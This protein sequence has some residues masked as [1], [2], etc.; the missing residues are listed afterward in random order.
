MI[1]LAEDELEAAVQVFHVR[2][3][4]VRGQRGWVVDKVEDVATGDLVEHLLQQVY[5][6]E[7]GDAVPREVLVPA[8]PD[9]AASR[10][11]LAVRAARRRG[12]PAGAAARR[13]ARPARDRGAQRAAGPDPAQDPARPA[14]SRPG[15][16]PS[17]ELQ[18]ALGLAEA[19]L[20]IEC[21][22]VSNL[23][24]T[25]VV[26]SMVVFEDGLPRKSRVPPV[27][28]PRASTGRTTSR[29][30]ARWSAAAS[31]A[32]STSVETGRPTS[33][34]TRPATDAR[35]GDVRAR[36]RPRDRPAAKFAYPPHLVV[37]DG[38]R[39]AGR[40][41]PGGPRRARASTTSRVCGLAKRLEEVWLPGD[42]R[43][44]DPAA[45]ERGPLPAAAGARRGAPL[46]DH[47]PPAAAVA[48][49]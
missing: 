31:G 19:P 28:R 3:G 22:D 12:R 13:Q 15:R 43:P 14:T 47:L 38:G 33:R 46:R 27:R 29:R 37:V 23:Q 20:R 17:S 21:F 32:T 40:R 48:S 35:P 16:W 25:E 26:A 36:H 30:C 49:R 2:G 18:E 6:D 34:S 9:D 10:R 8:L 7:S 39:A 45:H 4:R 1:A 44:G 5:G 41:P 11:R 24:G 42:A